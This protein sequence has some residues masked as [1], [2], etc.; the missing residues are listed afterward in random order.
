MLYFRGILTALLVVCTVAY[1]PSSRQQLAQPIPVISSNGGVA[2]AIASAA[3]SAWIC[4]SCLGVFPASASDVAAQI[5]LDKL[6]PTSVSIQIGD[7]PVVG[8]L[9]SGTYARVADGSIKDPS[10]TIR[11]PK[12]KVRAISS[13]ATGGHL[14][15]DVGGKLSS[16]FD[17]DVAADEAGTA[18]VIVKS[19]LIPKLPF[20][21][22]ASSTIGAPTGGR[23]SPWNIVTNLGSG[24]SYYYNAKSGLT[25]F[26]RPDKI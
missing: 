11:S 5:S 25:Q 3:L 15:F 18:K 19:N 13:I 14:E 17:V 8:S 16:H 4:T 9:L 2:K 21:N 1:Q 12:D 22:M 10:I 6:P 7:L 26:G 23:E 20:K 24:E